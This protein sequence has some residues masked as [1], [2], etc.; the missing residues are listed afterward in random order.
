MPT[1]TDEPTLPDVLAQ[2]A[3]ALKG[4]VRTVSPVVIEKYDLTTQRAEVRPVVRGR[5][6]DPVTDTEVPDLQAQPPVYNVPIMWPSG[7]GGWAITGPIGK[8]SPGVGF[9]SERSIDEWLDRGGEDV[10]PQ[11]ARRFDP[12]DLFVY[13]GGRNFSDDDR[14]GLLP[15]TAFDPNAVV[16]HVTG[17]ASIKLGDNTADVGSFL[18]PVFEG[19]FGDFLTALATAPDLIAVN[20]AAADLKTALATAVLQSSVVFVKASP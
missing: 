15:D 17:S 9:V 4:E 12:S 16:V 1:G 19:P 10:T 2:W 5:Y 13:P 6:H 14:T 20:T 8:G 7:L 11:D 3:R 18:Y